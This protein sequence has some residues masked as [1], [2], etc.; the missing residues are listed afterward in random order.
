MVSLLSSRWIRWCP[1]GEYIISLGVPFGNEFDGS[2]QEF[3][4]WT[5]K[6]RKTK[7]LM[8]RWAAIFAQ[9]YR[10]R[11]MLAN[12]MVYS[13]FRYWTQVMVIPEQI[14]EWIK[15]DVHELIWAKD[16]IF[17]ATEEGWSVG[18]RARYCFPPNLVPFSP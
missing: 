17:D 6:Y 14:N 10:G 12:S 7:A 13:R 3:D 8:A 18:T 2:K 9:T 5:S 15:Q 4:F 11:I 16:P 1:D